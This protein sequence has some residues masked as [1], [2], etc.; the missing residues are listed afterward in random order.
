MAENNPASALY[1]IL[2][3]VRKSGDSTVGKG[4]ERA[5]GCAVDDKDF[6]RRHGEVVQLFSRVNQ[7]L[8]S[9]PEDNEDRQ[10]YL[11]YAPRW[12]DAVV[13]RGNWNVTSSPAKRIVSGDI[14]NHLRGLGRLLQLKS[15]QN[16][17]TEAIDALRKGLAEWSTLLDSAEIPAALAERIRGQVDLIGWLL[18]NVETYGAEPVMRES[19]N[20]LGEGVDLIQAMPGKAK[21]IGLALAG[22]VYAIGLLHSGIDHTAGILEGLSEVG[23]QYGRLVEGLPQLE[24]PESPLEIEAGS[25]NGPEGEGSDE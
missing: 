12:Y 6:P 18:D 10:L 24:G 23:T 7:Y 4:W 3:T 14:L 20:L 25:Q 13:F 17:T 2:D 1:S 21:K 8:L 15:G 9:L 5:L 11:P 16:L 19:R 22:I